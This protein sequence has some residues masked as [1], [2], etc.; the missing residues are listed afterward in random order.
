MHPNKKT[1]VAAWAAEARACALHA[2][3]P[4]KAY[5]L[6]TLY[7]MT[8]IEPKSLHELLRGLPN[9]I[10]TMAPDPASKSKLAVPYFTRKENTSPALA[11][12]LPGEGDQTA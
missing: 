4:G 3:E 5:N 1:V 7:R 6:A 12:G 10:K 2:M 11:G 9:V 8:G